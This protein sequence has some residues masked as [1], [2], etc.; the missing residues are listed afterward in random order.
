MSTGVGWVYEYALVD[1]TGRHDLAQLRTLQ[2]WY[3]RYPLQAVDGVAEVASIGGFVKQY[4]VEVDPNALLN[5]N[6]PLSKVKTAIQ[7][8][9][10][11]AGGKI[12]EMAETEY[13]VRGLG[14]IQSINDLKIDCYQRE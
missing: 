14:Y 2:D 8:S 4:Q 5:Y 10:S 13:M 3:F 1:K 12:I 9:N 6:I 11:D 7:R